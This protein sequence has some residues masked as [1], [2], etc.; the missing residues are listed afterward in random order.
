M[1]YIFKEKVSTKKNWSRKFFH[2]FLTSFLL[3]C[4]WIQESYLHINGKLRRLDRCVEGWVGGLMWTSI[5]FTHTLNP[6]KKSWVHLIHWWSDDTILSI[7]TYK[8]NRIISNLR[9]IF[10]MIYFFLNRKTQSRDRSRTE[11]TT[12]AA[13]FPNNRE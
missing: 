9:N 7:H 13:I 3:Q 8:Q 10:F 4:R 5:G 6:I 2:L 11:R 1:I 12:T